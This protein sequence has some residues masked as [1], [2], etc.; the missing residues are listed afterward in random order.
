MT[1]AKTT[2]LRIGLSGVYSGATMSESIKLI[3]FNESDTAYVLFCKSV[4]LENPKFT[5][6]RVIEEYAKRWKNMDSVQRKPFEDAANELKKSQKDKHVI[7]FRRIEKQLD[8]IPRPYM[9][10]SGALRNADTAD[11]YY[12]T[13]EIYDSAKDFVETY[14]ENEKEH[15]GIREILHEFEKTS[16]DVDY[17]GFTRYNDL[18]TDTY[19]YEIEEYNER[20]SD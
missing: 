13:K 10:R 3:K 8:S 18:E 16:C 20:E 2:Y 12:E 7:E 9:G 6:L 5:G 15:I 19:F 14:Y 4:K 17:E 11:K 1:I